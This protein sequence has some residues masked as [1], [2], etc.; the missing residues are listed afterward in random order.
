M[1][2]EDGLRDLTPQPSPQTRMTTRTPIDKRSPKSVWDDQYRSLAEQPIAWTLMADSLS[3]VF[4][5]LAAQTGRDEEAT[6]RTEPN[7]RHVTLMIGG[8]AIENL[9]KGLLVSANGP[10]DQ[11]GRF[12]LD[13]HNLM[14]LAQDTNLG[15]TDDER[16]VLERLEVFVKWAGRYPIPK[17]SDDMRPRTL[18]TG[19]APL[20]YGYAD[21]DIAACRALLAK[22]RSLLSS[23]N[24]ASDGA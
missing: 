12:R 11:E 22:L 13:T 7:L 20:T 4:E 18:A 15:L 10:W 9:L 16:L 1:S 6:P 24:H 8:F 19:Y 23:I 17:T 2:G 3:R 14:Q 5:L 21:E